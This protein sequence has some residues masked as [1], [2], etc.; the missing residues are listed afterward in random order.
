MERAWPIPW[1]ASV[2]LVRCLRPKQWAKNLLLFAGLLFT[3]DQAHTAAEW[4]RV[5]IAFLLFCMVSSAVYLFN[6]LADRERDRLHPVKRFRPIASGE[7]ATGEAGAVGALLALGSGIAAYSCD[8]RLCLLL[9]GYFLLTLL[10]SFH[11]KHVVILDVLAIAAGFVLRAVAGTTILG[12]QIS[13]WLLICTTLLALFLG[14]AKRRA[15]LSILSDEA[16]R[17]RRALGE[18]T[19][20]MLDQMIATVTS[21]TLMAYAFYTFNSP[22]ALGHRYLMATIPF[23]I[24]GI[25][26]YLYLVHRRNV[27]GSPASELLAD[28]PLVV[29][30]LLWGLACAGIIRY[31]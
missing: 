19:P 20:G 31:G 22:T 15:E 5:S 30:I 4:L 11:L 24:Y 17:H 7:I 10:Y 2:P 26:R 18:Y 21:S 1:I 3:L 13:P 28:R 29:T 9:A 12:V 23:V 8:P 6:D 14:L 25:F 27:G 16:G